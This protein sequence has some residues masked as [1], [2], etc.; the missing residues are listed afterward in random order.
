LS[1]QIIQIPSPQVP[2]LMARAL[3]AG[4]SKALA[5]KAQS[6]PA[7]HA[8]TLGSKTQWPQWFLSRLF[9]SK[10]QFTDNYYITLS[11]PKHDSSTAVFSLAAL[12]TQS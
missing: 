11:T 5:T 2:T 9:T 8:E 1:P 12:R 10:L 4:T 3:G 6:S 7:Q